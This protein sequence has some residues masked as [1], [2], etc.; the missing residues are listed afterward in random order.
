MFG[1]WQRQDWITTVERANRLEFRGA[2]I[3]FN[4]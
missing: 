1:L 3:G 2:A 4:P